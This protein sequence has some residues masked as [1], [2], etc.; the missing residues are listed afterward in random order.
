MYLDEH[1]YA[2]SVASCPLCNTN[3]FS[4]HHTKRANLTE[5]VKEGTRAIFIEICFFYFL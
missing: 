3:F 4:D 1:K 5:K 2:E